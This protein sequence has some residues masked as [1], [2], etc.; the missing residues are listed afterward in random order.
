MREK[1]EEGEKYEDVT[2]E[3]LSMIMRV[4]SRKLC[5]PI[6]LSDDNNCNWLPGNLT[7]LYRGLTVSLSVL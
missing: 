1:K 5:P 6:T 2:P 7:Y 3:W 4:G